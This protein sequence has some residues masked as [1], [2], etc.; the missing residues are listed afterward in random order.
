[1]QWYFSDTIPKY[2]EKYT[3]YR[4]LRNQDV[5]LHEIT[6]LTYERSVFTNIDW[7]ISYTLS[8]YKDAIEDFSEGYCDK[9]D[10]DEEEIFAINWLYYLK[11][12]EFPKWNGT[13]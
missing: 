8:E 13:D 3:R 1:M 12:G 6:D 2:R 10:Y 5:P 7:W 9:K 4:K 11:K